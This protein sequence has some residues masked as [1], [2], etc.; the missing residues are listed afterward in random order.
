ME[1]QKNWAGVILAEADGFVSVKEWAPGLQAAF[2]IQSNVDA[3]T[4]VFG[5]SV[6]QKVPLTLYF[7][8]F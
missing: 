5:G 4:L 1:R 8:M 2:C 3:P 6:F 7:G